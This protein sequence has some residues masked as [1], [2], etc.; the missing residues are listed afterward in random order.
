MLRLTTVLA[1]MSLP[2]VLTH[3]VCFHKRMRPPPSLFLPTADALVL[4][5]FPVA[6]FFGF[7]YYTEVPS[8]VSVVWTVVAACQDRHWLAALVR[9]TYFAILIDKLKMCGWQL[10]LISCTFRQTNIVWVLYAYA[11]SQLMYLRF[12]RGVPGASLKKLHDPPALSAT[13]GMCDFLCP[14]VDRSMFRHLLQDDIRFRGSGPI[15][16]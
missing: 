4:G 2:L 10:G 3:L 6:W 1:L 15:C 13:P 8:L 7:L 14:L 16:S 5:T 9:F 11:A 12:R